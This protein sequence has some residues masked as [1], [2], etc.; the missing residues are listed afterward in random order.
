MPTGA[1]SMATTKLRG[2]LGATPKAQHLP[3]LIEQ[4]DRAKGA[5]HDPLDH[6]ANGFEHGGERRIRGDLLEYPALSRRNGLAAL[7]LGD[8][9]DAGANQSAIGARKADEAHLAGHVVAVRVAMHPFEHRR[10]A[11][12]RTVDISSRHTEGGTAVGLPR[13]TDPFRS[14][15][16]QRRPIHLEEA[17]RVVVDVDEFAL[18]DIE[19]H[20]DFGGI[21][22]QGPV[23]GL[24]LPHGLLRQV[25]FGDIPNAHD[26]AVAPIEARL[27]DGNFDR[28]A[29]AFLGY[30]PCPVSGKIDVRIVDFRGTAFEK[31]ERSA[32]VDLRAAEN[33]ACG[34]RSRPGSS[35]KYA[36]RWD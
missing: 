29:R 32:R 22:H 8:I 13:R 6:L 12:Q 31:I 10:T 36:R 5:R 7:A 35:R 34:P 18:I 2:R 9:G 27:A 26:E 1:R 30:A 19:Y 16:E 24:A 25:P 14:A 15:L 3:L 23:A 33:P 20:D 17:A 21:L 4:I 28:D 11:R